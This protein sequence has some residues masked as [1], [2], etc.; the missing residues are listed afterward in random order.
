MRCSRRRIPLRSTKPRRRPF[1]LKLE[2]VPESL[3]TR[4]LRAMQGLGKTRWDTLRRNLRKAG[5][6]RCAICGGSERL[7]G[8]E[9][10]EYEDRPRV[11]VARLMRVEVTCQKC[12]LVNHWGRTKQLIAHGK[13]KHAGH[14]ALRKHFRTVNRCSQSDFERHIETSFAIWRTRNTKKW[15]VEWGDFAPMLREAEAGRKTWAEKN[16]RRDVPGV[17]D[18]SGPGHHMPS[19]C[20]SCRAEN[21]LEPIDEDMT[22]MSDGQSAEYMA[23]TW[24]TA[25]CHACGHEVDWQI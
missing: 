1:K 3:W 19:R 25:I 14:M 4:N 16:R 13:I 15:R 17:L 5:Q 24:G 11:S 23:G 8:H 9:V 2:L 12:H 7:H 21:T 20:P 6:T 10:W 18:L 22:E